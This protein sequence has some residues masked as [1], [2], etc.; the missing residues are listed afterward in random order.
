MLKDE[1]THIQFC[2]KGQSWVFP[3]IYTQILFSL[4]SNI[5]YETMNNFCLLVVN[6]FVF[7]G[8]LILK[9]LFELCVYYNGL[10]AYTIHL[11]G[12]KL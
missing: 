8:E 12:E 9:F 1:S 11:G 3:K 4:V 5:V 6:K 7:D 10:H 2:I